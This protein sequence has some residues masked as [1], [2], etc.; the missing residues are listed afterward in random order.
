[1]PTRSP[2]GVPPEA[3]LHETLRRRGCQRGRGAV[4]PQVPFRLVAS[5]DEHGRGLA[6]HGRGDR[7]EERQ[8]QY[9]THA[10]LAS[11]PGV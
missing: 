3:R 5:A 1:M 8:K 11:C 6:R 2:A 10:S 7:S 4:D 9:E